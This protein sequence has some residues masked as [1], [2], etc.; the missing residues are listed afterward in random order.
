MSKDIRELKPVAGRATYRSP[1]WFEDPV[2]QLH[3][4]S[5]CIDDPG[6]KHE[7]RHVVQFLEERRIDLFQVI[8]T[9]SAHDALTDEGARLWL[10]EHPNI[11]HFLDFLVPGAKFEAQ[12]ERDEAEF[13]VFVAGKNG[14]KMGPGFVTIAA[15]DSGWKPD[16]SR[17][18]PFVG[19]VIYYRR[20]PSLPERKA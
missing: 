11:L 14:A 18:S 2:K 16:E 6:R 9:K 3:L 12:W 10:S 20:S 4:V 7:L 19:T 13:A 1:Y 15:V 5:D 8:P 17:E